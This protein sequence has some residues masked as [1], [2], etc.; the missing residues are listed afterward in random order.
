MPRICELDAGR[1][2]R[3]ALP[4]CNGAVCARRARVSDFAPPALFPCRQAALKSVCLLLMAPDAQR[5]EIDEVALTAALG[6]RKDVIGVPEAGAPGVDIEP[7]CQ[8]FAL[9]RRQCFESPEERHRV[10]ATEG[11]DPPIAGKDLLSQVG[12]I[13]AQAPFVNTRFAAECPP[14]LGHFETAPTADSSSVRAAFRRAEDPSARHLSS[15]RHFVLW[16]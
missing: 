11:T 15:G 10:Q 2:A 9:G 1:L 4:G 13:R 14:A 6:D 16:L 7:P 5:P 8:A 12:G 3:I